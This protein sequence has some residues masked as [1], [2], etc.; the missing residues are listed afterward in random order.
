MRDP[1]AV[2]AIWLRLRSLRD[3]QVAARQLTHPEGS[4]GV[5]VEVLAEAGGELEGPAVAWARHARPRGAEVLDVALLER[6][7]LVR[8][9]RVDGKKVASVRKEGEAAPANLNA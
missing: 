8:A 1:D 9:V 3:A 2:S 6:C 5:V 4:H 7:T